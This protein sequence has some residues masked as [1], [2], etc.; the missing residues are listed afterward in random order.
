MTIDTT[1]FATLFSVRR[2]NGEPLSFPNDLAVVS[3]LVNE[4]FNNVGQHLYAP[5]VRLCLQAPNLVL[6]S[7][8][9][10]GKAY[11]TWLDQHT[12]SKPRLMEYL[13]SGVA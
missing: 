1:P 12:S 6:R 4:V 5:I 11:M 3:R 7:D 9:G 2:A 10:T 13:R 8:L